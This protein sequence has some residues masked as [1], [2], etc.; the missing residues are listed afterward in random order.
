VQVIVACGS[1]SPPTLL[2]LRIFEDA[3]TA[4]NAS[5]KYTV[6]GGYLS[7][8]HI[9]YGKKSLVENFHRVNLV[10]AAVA[11]STCVPRSQRP[12]PLVPFLPH[13][14]ACSRSLWLVLLWK[15]ERGGDG[16]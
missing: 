10:K 13:S 12:R 5:G 15:W 7:P 14:P 6:I 1:F 3:K 11:D 2:H 9:D 16:G 8:V 4:L